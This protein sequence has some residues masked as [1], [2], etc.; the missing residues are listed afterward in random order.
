MLRP[1]KIVDI[2]FLIFLGTCCLIT[3]YQG[4]SNVFLLTINNYLAVIVYVVVVGLKVYSPSK[5]RYNVLILLVL[6][7]FNLINFSAVVINSTIYHLD[8]GWSVNGVGFNI[9]VF[10]FIIIYFFLNKDFVTYTLRSLLVESDKEIV[11][12]K[13]KMVK[14]Y[15]N[16]FK[17]E[18]NGEFD[19]IYFN[20][21]SY[22]DEAQIALEKLK[23][24]RK[25]I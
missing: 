18:T 7:L 2:S 24:D 6:S 11:A 8:S 20:I 21:K 19:R 14:F 3:I 13:E 10:V 4:V 9:I 15:Y 22:P 23:E 25:E 17:K 16:K 12:K 1:N 5:G